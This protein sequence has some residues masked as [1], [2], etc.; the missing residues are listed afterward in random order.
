MVMSGRLLALAL[1]AALLTGC[2]GPASSSGSSGSGSLSSSGGV[3]SSGS[4]DGSGDA[5]APQTPQFHVQA[6]WS[7]LEEEEAQPLPAVGSRWYE[8]AAETLTPREDYG[9]LVPY[10][11]ALCYL[12]YP[13]MGEAGQEE[14]ADA[15]PSNL[16]GLMTLDGRVVLDPVCSSIS[17]ASYTTQAGESAY[18]P[19]LI[20]QKGDQAQ[21]QPISGTL[22]AIAAADGRW[23]TGFQYW[24]CAAGPNN[25]LA[26]NAG[27]L[28][29]IAPENGETV[30]HWSWAE[31]GIDQPESF[32][33]FT[34]DA[35]STAQ[36]ADGLFFL[37]CFGDSW[38]QAR[39]L[40]PL[41]GAVTVTSAQEWYDQLNLRYSSWT[42]WSIEAAQDGTVTLTYEGEKFRFP[43]PLPDD[44]HPYVSGSDRV[45]F[46][47]SDGR[48]A[49]TAL[50]GT[51]ILPAQEGTLAVLQSSWEAASPWLA[52]QSLD[53]TQW[54]LYDW[55][56]KQSAVLPAS[57]GSWCDMAGPLVGVIENRCAS[58]YRPEDG[59]CVFRTYFG[60]GS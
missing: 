44:Q 52:V 1:M 6:D 46:S 55:K 36:W 31:L 12:T 35:S 19:I 38:D 24:G 16:Y 7:V 22:T 28:D 43:S 9:T 2:A 54:T 49:V 25:L 39:F 32:P 14:P 59:S 5:S 8:G 58:Y 42:G 60:L 10:A 48:F 47:T 56:G 29:L 50:D 37:G 45:I 30:N 20:L 26:G 4:P 23:S 53:G 40:D 15:Y 13:W 34:G 11:G 27:G 3:S 33:W 57:S 41:T 21:G 17:R 18:L 51:V